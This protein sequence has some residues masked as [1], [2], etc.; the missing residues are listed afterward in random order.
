VINI[1]RPPLRYRLQPKPIHSPGIARPIRVGRPIESPTRVRPVSGIRTIA[2][3]TVEPIRPTQGASSSFRGTRPI[4]A[5]LRRDFPVSAPSHRPGNSTAPERGNP[6][7][8]V[9][10]E[11]GRPVMQPGNVQPGNPVNPG[12]GMERRDGAASRQMRP[13]PSMDQRQVRPQQ[14]MRQGAPQQQIRPAEP[15][16]SQ[17]QEPRYSQPSQP[18][19]APQP[20]YS[21]PPQPH[22][23]PPPSAPRSA[24][25]APAPAASHK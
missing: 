23:A 19:Y 9:R 7:V 17:P 3:R 20:H 2:G 24:P 12:T 13:Q 15:R 5:S 25:S 22:Y 1:A 6:A 18:H 8:R 14:Q 16:S 4:G 21:P 11:E 10:P